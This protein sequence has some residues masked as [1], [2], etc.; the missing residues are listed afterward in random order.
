MSA[1][2]PSNEHALD[3]VVRLIL[4][5][6]LFGLIA[7]DIVSGMAATAVVGVAGGILMLT[8]LVGTCPIYTA[9]GLSTASKQA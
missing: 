2:F 9:L 6:G 7:L 3:R 5:A 1:L 4:G 8:G